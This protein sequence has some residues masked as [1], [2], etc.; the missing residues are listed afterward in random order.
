MKNQKN[1]DFAGDFFWCF[2]YVFLCFYVFL[3]LLS[4]QDVDISVFTKRLRLRPFGLR[5]PFGRKTFQPG[6]NPNG[7]GADG[8]NLENQK[9]LDFST[10]LFSVG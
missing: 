3:G 4:K 1:L 9:N 8:V 7:P 5:S 6:L 2:L 10:D